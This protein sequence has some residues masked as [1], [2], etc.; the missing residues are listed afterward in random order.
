MDC[1]EKIGGFM[2]PHVGVK[3]RAI[4]LRGACLPMSDIDDFMESVKYM[5]C[6]D[7]VTGG[8]WPGEGRYYAG[9]RFL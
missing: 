2:M 6:M 7:A 9:Y 5:P 8:G 3:Y 1:I 4:T